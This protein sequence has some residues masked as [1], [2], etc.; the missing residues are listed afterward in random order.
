MILPL[1]SAPPAKSQSFPTQPTLPKRNNPPPFLVRGTRTFV[2]WLC[3]PLLILFPSSSWTA[4]AR[5]WGAVLWRRCLPRARVGAQSGVSP[6]HPRG[7]DQRDVAG[8]LFV[9]MMQTTHDVFQ[10]QPAVGKYGR[11][12][13]ND[14]TIV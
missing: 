11:R 4:A 1:S 14:S 3:F 6:P 7:N 10:R 9:A 8:T 12:A 13:D 5:G 2:L